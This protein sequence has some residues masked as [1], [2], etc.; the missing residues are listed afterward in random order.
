MT[1]WLTKLFRLFANFT[2]S[3]AALLLCAMVGLFVITCELLQAAYIGGRSERMIVLLGLI[4]ILLSCSV[5]WVVLF[6]TIGKRL[7]W[8]PR[9]VR[10]VPCFAA[11]AIACMPFLFPPRSYGL[12]P[13]SLSTSFF[14]FTSF[15]AWYGRQLVYPTLG[16]RDPD[17]LD[18]IR[19]F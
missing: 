18:H 10:Q 3:R 11:L 8:N 6:A 7:Q 1:R 19:L 14:T 12:L 4:T 9:T 2:V 16:P 15:L 17:P 5:A 13:T